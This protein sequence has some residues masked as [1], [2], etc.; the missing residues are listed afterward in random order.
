MIS[1]K[2]EYEKKFFEDWAIDYDE[3]RNKSFLEKSK[4]GMLK[5]M[6][7]YEKNKKNFS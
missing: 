4:H 3:K 5:P 1:K 2:Q 6:A 7:N